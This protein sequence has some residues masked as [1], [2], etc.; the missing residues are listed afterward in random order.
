M[1]EEEDEDDEEDEE[2]DESDSSSQE[3]DHVWQWLSGAPMEYT[4]WWGEGPDDSGMGKLKG[5]C[6]QLL[7][8]APPAPATWT[9]TTGPG[10]PP[11]P[12]APTTITTTE[13]FARCKQTKKICRLCLLFQNIEN[14]L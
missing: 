3:S 4:N 2:D 9:P 13:S 12:S 5:G 1:G 14:L 7:G 6:I 11:T 8:R 10:R